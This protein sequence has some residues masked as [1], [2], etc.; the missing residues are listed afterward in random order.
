MSPKGRASPP[1]FRP[2]CALPVRARCASP[3]PDVVGSSVPCAPAVSCTSART[4]EPETIREFCA[5]SNRSDVVGLVAAAFPTA[6]RRKC[7]HHGPAPVSNTHENVSG[8]CAARAMARARAGAGLRTGTARHN[9]TT[10]PGS[11]PVPGLP[12]LSHAGPGA[13]PP[14]GPGDPSWEKH[15]TMG[16]VGQGI[17]GSTAPARLR[18]EIAV[19]WKVLVRPW[20]QVGTFRWTSGKTRKPVPGHPHAPARMVVHPQQ[21]STLRPTRGPAGGA[22]PSGLLL[23]ALSS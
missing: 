5:P 2:G 1:P 6:R 23:P 10:D 21:H 16:Q 14:V 4:L 11:G 17:S 7:R 13:R 15:V 12:E 9:D 8:A 18:V 19:S 3:S 22:N 20:T